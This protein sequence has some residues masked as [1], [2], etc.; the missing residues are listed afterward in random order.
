V[1]RLFRL[2]R[3]HELAQLRVVQIGYSPERHACVDPMLDIEPSN[4]W[5]EASG[6]IVSLGEDKHVDGVLLALIDERGDWSSSNVV[7]TAANERKPDRGE[8]NDRRGR[9]RACPETT[10]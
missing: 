7:E 1:C 6:D 9:N 2:K 3:L 8:V 5:G 10:A 4:R